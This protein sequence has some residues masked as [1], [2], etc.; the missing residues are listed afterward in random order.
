MSLTWIALAISIPIVFSFGM[1]V[2]LYTRYRAKKIIKE[3]NQENKSKKLL[4]IQLDNKFLDLQTKQNWTISEFSFL[5]NT[6]NVNNYQ[7]I[8]FISFDDA[9]E[10]L[11]IANNIANLQVDLI[12]TNHFSETNYQA[13]LKKKNFDNEL[14]FHKQLNIIQFADL[15]DSSLRKYDCLIIHDKDL[16]LIN[17]WNELKK[18]LKWNASIIFI[19]PSTSNQKELKE[20]L[21]KNYYRYDEFTNNKKYFLI[22]N[23]NH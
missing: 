3:L 23:D 1:L 2:Y 17:T 11:I 6:L 22:S 4:D 8:L 10:A 19:D 20:Y 5:L 18:F 21:N 15:Q 7:K 9:L 16:S 12:D 14:Y 13:L